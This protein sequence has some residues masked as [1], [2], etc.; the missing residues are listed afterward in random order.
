MKIVNR[1]FIIIRPT[2][3]F[4]KWAN[5]ND[6]DYQDL[7]E[8]EPNVYLIEEEFY[9]DELVLKSYFKNIF[10]NEL[11]A[12]SEDESTYPEIKFEVF[13]EWFDAEL[14]GTVFDSQSSGLN[15]D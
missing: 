9:D 5:A 7:T 12:V 2:E 1:G 13:N 10:L 4:W 11:E 8:G 14:G 6:E 3:A 15:R